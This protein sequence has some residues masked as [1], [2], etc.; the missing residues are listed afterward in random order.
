MAAVHTAKPAR[1]SRI[2][3]SLES[4]SLAPASASALSSCIVQGSAVPTEAAQLVLS[5]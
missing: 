1:A 2:A 3:F 4:R 5:A